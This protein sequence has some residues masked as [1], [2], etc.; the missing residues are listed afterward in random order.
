M[1]QKAEDIQ[2]DRMDFIAW[3]KEYKVQLIFAW[4]SII[5]LISVTS[6][7]YKEAIIELWN[8]LK[9]VF[10]IVQNGLKI[11]AY[12]NFKKEEILFTKII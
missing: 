4:L 9:K 11:R 10:Y 6:M 5:T 3:I 1:Q 12:M 7:K 8:S 2:E